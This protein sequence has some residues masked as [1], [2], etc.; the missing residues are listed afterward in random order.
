MA[1]TPD[2]KTLTEVSASVLVRWG[3]PND[4]QLDAAAVHLPVLDR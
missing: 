2:M 3:G 1:I 4:S